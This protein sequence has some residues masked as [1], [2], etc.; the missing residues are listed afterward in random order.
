MTAGKVQEFIVRYASHLTTLEWELMAHLTT[1]WEHRLLS[2][3]H[4]EEC[5]TCHR[6][7]QATRLEKSGEAT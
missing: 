1:L 3:K 4:V 7:V 6:K 2:S 5:M